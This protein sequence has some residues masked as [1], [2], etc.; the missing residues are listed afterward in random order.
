M[1]DSTPDAAKR[2][3]ALLPGASSPEVDP[4]R[5]PRWNPDR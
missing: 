4:A 1:S 3:L 2:A 5:G